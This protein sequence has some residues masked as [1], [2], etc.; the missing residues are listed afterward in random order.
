MVVT[1]Y[2][3]S[4][5]AVLASSNPKAQA[6]RELLLKEYPANISSDPDVIVALGGDG[7]MLEILHQQI[8]CATPVFGM[9]RGSVGFLMNDFSNENLLQRLNKSEPA[10]I[11]P[12][13]MNGETIDG[14]RFNGLAI[15]EVSL[16]RQSHQAAKIEILVDGKQRMSELIADGVLVSTPTGST[17]YNLSA[18]GTIIPL[19]ARVLALTP[20]SSFRPRRWRG[21]LLNHQSVVRFNIVEPEKRKVSAVADNREVRNIRFVEIRES[22]SLKL[23]MLFDEERALGE[24]I[25]LEQFSS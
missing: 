11:R 25:A 17:A 20:I 23:T 13:R 8:G 21:A 14:K 10:V 16:L 6:A 19:D 1:N 7:F 5:I 15:N 18:H 9:N 22:K 4:S 3:F 24:R 2:K 12:L